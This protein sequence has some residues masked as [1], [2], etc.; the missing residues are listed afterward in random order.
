[1]TAFQAVFRVA[2]VA[3]LVERDVPNVNVEGSNPFARFE[4]VS[5]RARLD[6]YYTSFFGGKIRKRM[7]SNVFNVLTAALRSYCFSLSGNCR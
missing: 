2:G 3:Q 6:S 7:A 4:R 5:R 1:L